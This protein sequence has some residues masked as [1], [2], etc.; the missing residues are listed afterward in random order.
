MFR[1]TDSKLRVACADV[2]QTYDTEPTMVKLITELTESVTL[3][4][5]EKM[6]KSRQPQI[7]LS[8]NRAALTKINQ[9]SAGSLLFQVE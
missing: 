3:Q 5:N 7:I 2:K 8:Q 9:F 6:P 4:K 1:K